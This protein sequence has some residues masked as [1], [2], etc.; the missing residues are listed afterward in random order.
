[1]DNF[2]VIYRILR[3]LERMMDCEETD[4]TPIT[5]ESLGI[6]RMRWEQIMIMLQSNGYIDGVVYNRC[7]TDDKPR[8]R[9]PV[10]PIIT[11]KGLEYLA[12]NSLMKKAGGLL[13]GA[14][15]VIK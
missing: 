12:E 6:S 8:V 15:D 3:A 10:T 11:L 2:K 1:M 9:E 13:K 4:I 5:H 14:I 7:I